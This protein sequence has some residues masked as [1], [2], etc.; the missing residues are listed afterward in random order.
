[1]LSSPDTTE[2]TSRQESAMQEFCRFLK[3]PVQ[4]KF[5]MEPCNS[6]AVLLHWKVLLS[7][8]A[9]LKEE[10]RDY[11]KNNFQAP[12]E[13]VVIEFQLGAPVRV[14]PEALNAHFHLD[15]TLRDMKLPFHGSLE[16]I[17][18]NDPVDEYKKINLVGSVAIYC[19]P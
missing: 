12:E 15:R 4:D 9:S 14:T 7:I 16:D 18:I 5:V 11:L 2:I 6:P 1:M 13:A 8:A 3:E 10:E 19:D 17:L